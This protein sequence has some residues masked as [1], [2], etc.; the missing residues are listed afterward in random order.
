MDTKQWMQDEQVKFAQERIDEILSRFTA[1]VTRTWKGDGNK[2]TDY[3]AID[4]GDGMFLAIER[5]NPDLDFADVIEAGEYD[6][7]GAQE[8]NELRV[9]DEKGEWL[10]ANVSIYGPEVDRWFY[11]DEDKPVEVKDAEVSHSSGGRQIREA[12]ATAETLILAAEYA[13]AV[14]MRAKP[15]LLAQ[16]EE[17]KRQ[18]AEERKKMEEQDNARKWRKQ[19][20]LDTVLDKVVRVTIEGR[21]TPLVGKLNSAGGSNTVAIDTPFGKQIGFVI[22]G[23]TKL[24]EKQDNGTYGV[25]EFDFDLAKY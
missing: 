5:G 11:R 1:T 17:Q 23:I 4:L 24:E 7:Y 19:K 2:K 25:V 15:Y 10:G 16:A 20:L 8:I 9:L 18:W 3:R 14:T 13:E 6:K 12:R 22:D 21:K